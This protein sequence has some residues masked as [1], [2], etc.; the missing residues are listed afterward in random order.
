MVSPPRIM[1]PA[2]QF[3]GE[4]ASGSLNN[5]NIARQAACNP[6]AGDHSFFR[7][8]KQTS[9]VRKCTLG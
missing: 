7:I 1:L 3:N 9:P 2:S 4:S 8:S 6:H 5:A